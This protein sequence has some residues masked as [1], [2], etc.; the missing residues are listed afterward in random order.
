MNLGHIHYSE[1]AL[2]SIIK[3]EALT[4]HPVSSIQVKMDEEEGFYVFNLDI[5]FNTKEEITLKLKKM[6]SSIVKTLETMTD[7]TNV[8]VNIYLK[9]LK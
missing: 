5:V 3:N 7:L 9:S 1:E 2:V 6:Q 4:N 8:K